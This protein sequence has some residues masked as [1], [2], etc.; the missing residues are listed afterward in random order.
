MKEISVGKFSK[1]KQSGQRQQGFTI[2][3]LVIA[4]IAGSVLVG[5]I[6]V[7]SSNYVHLNQKGRNLALTNSYVEAKIESLR[8]VGYLSLANGTTDLSGELPGGLPSPKSGSMTVTDQG[9]GLKKVV[10]SV[11]YN[12]KGVDRTYSYSTLVGELGVGN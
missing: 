8:N 7:A 6:Q 2:V 10:M 4:I 1:E 5:G 11:T 12:D 3:E 9:S